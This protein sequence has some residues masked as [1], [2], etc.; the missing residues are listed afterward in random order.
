MDDCIQVKNILIRVYLTL[1]FFT[2]SLTK[3]SWELEGWK[4]DIKLGS[5]K[6]FQ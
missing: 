3:C 6:T 2:F 5:F 4:V 1:F